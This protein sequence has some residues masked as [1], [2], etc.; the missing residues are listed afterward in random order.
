M[1]IRLKNFVYHY[2]ESPVSSGNYSEETATRQKL[3]EFVQAKQ[4][5][6]EEFLRK[7]NIPRKLTRNSASDILS[8]RSETP[9][10]ATDIITEKY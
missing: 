4:R 5:S 9:V 7:A 1:F 8:P 6:S 10:I 2:L 3:R